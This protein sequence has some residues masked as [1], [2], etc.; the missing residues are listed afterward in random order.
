M[1]KI[2]SPLGFAL[3][4]LLVLSSCSSKPDAPIPADA[5]FV[6]HINGK[7]MSEKLPWSEVK[8]SEWFKSIAENVNGDSLGT[9]LLNDPAQSGININSDGWAFVANRGKGAYSAL[10]WGLDDAEKFEKLIKQS[11]PNAKIQEKESIRYMAEGTALLA[12]KGKRLMLLGDA[13]EFTRELNGLSNTESDAIEEPFRLTNDS[14]LKIAL[15]IEG[16]KS[17]NKL[18]NDDKFADLINNKGDVHF[19]F[20]TGKMYGNTLAGSLLSL[21][22]LSALLEGNIGAITVNFNDGS[23]DIESKGY[24]GK[25]LEALYK[26]YPASN[27]DENALKNLPAGEVNFALAMN[28]PPE[29]IKAL[30]MLFGVDG[31]VNNFMQEAGFS[32][33]EFIKANG[34][35][36]FFSLSD[37]NIKKVEKSYE[38]FDGEPVTYSSSEPSGKLLFGADVKERSAFQKMMDVAK[39]LLTSK[40]SMSEADLNK[41]PYVL[42]DKWFL[43]GNDSAQINNYGSKKTD[44]AFIDRIKD[45]PIGMYVNISSFIKGSSAELEED[46]AA[47]GMADLSLKFWK[48]MI[49]TGGEFK[50]GATISQL[51][52][53]LGDPNTNSL[54]GLNQYL[55]QIAKIVKEDELRRQKEWESTDSTIAD[56]SY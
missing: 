44:H 8:Q 31:L 3:S 26:K 25:E 27:F 15:E 45:H 12:W 53:S 11:A 50:K 55:G 16:L 48:D 40:G 20:N 32:I 56:P 35:N 2:L 19:W 9:V 42:K 22:K 43:S 37:F 36:L 10:I 13:S 29:G 17:S 34:G 47:K 4:F 1:K 49:L 30:L 46:P 54:K 28:Y 52:L 24:V 6:M 7:T 23:I 18:T 14:L 5:A 39:K 38:G 33:D 41:V 21:S 51:R